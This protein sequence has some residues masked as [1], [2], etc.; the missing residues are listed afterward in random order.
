M[1]QPNGE[2]A[3]FRDK[4]ER[5]KTFRPKFLGIIV[6]NALD[7][8]S[9]NSFVFLSKESLCYI[10]VDENSFKGVRRIKRFEFNICNT[11]N[12]NSKLSSS[13]KQHVNSPWQ[14]IKNFARIM[15]SF[16]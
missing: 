14:L 1:L 10:Q 5:K 9:T 6:L 15:A 13:E 16:M 12:F 4:K 3:C 7:K 2:T 8:A 11:T